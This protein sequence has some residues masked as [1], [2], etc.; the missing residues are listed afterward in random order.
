MSD[1][2]GRASL[3]ARPPRAPGGAMSGP[4]RKSALEGWGWQSEQALGRWEGASGEAALWIPA[5]G[6]RWPW[7]PGEQRSQLL[8]ASRASRVRGGSVLGA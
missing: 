3:S 7:A 8:P 5:A 4:A 1:A 2:R 6:S